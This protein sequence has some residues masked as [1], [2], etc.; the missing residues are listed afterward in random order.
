MYSPFYIHLLILCIP[1]KTFFFHLCSLCINKAIEIQKEL[2]RQISMVSLLLLTASVWYTLWYR[3][4]AIEIYQKH[5]ILVR[6]ISECASTRKHFHIMSMCWILDNFHYLSI[7]CMF[8]YYR[9]T[10][11]K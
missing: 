4:K 8:E 1:K 10:L 2:L 7:I 9:R 3:K 5:I 6:C 11:I